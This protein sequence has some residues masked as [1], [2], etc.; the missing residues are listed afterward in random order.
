M[1]HFRSICIIS[2]LILY[3]VENVGYVRN[4]GS[5]VYSYSLGSHRDLGFAEFFVCRKVFQF[6]FHITEYR[7]RQLQNDVKNVRFLFTLCFSFC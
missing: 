6:V 2:C 1:F 7:L 3:A 4:D 5:C